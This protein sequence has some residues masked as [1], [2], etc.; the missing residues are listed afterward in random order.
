MWYTA[1]FDES[2]PSDSNRENLLRVIEWNHMENY[3]EGCV[4]LIHKVGD[5]WRYVFSRSVVEEVQR[6]QG[7]YGW[8]FEFKPYAQSFLKKEVTLFHG[9]EEEF[10]RYCR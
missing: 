6:R 10:N 8:S 1:I 9:K 3:L 2:N 4:V 7:Q 5:D